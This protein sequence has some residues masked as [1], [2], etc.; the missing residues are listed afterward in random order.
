MNKGLLLLALMPLACARAAD[1]PPTTGAMS[2]PAEAAGVTPRPTEVVRAASQPTAGAATISVDEL[3]H[4]F[5]STSGAADRVK[6]SVVSEEGANK[7]REVSANHWSKVHGDKELAVEARKLCS[8][9]KSTRNGSEFAAALIA[10]DKRERARVQQAARRTLE[11]LS[12][13]DRQ[14]LEN[15]LNTEY[16]RGFRGGGMGPQ[17]TETFA[18]ASFPSESTEGITREAC[19]AAAEFERRAKP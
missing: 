2:Q 12:Q 9:L 19:N 10:S 11:E 4:F 16:R 6:G 14:E 13:Q 17:L 5:L 1:P 15:W 8:D 3:A 18:S 7:L